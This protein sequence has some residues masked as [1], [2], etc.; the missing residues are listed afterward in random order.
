[1]MISGVDDLMECGLLTCI[2]TSPPKVF[3]V[4]GCLQSFECNYPCVAPPV[5]LQGLPCI[6]HQRPPA[7]IRLYTYQIVSTVLFLFF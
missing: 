5:A 6:P 7:G 4:P 2:P 3:T 1:M